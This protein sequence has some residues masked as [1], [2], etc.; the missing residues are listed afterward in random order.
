M[1]NNENK[2]V[3]LN[4]E[5]GMLEAVSGGA[6]P[7]PPAKAGFFLHQVTARDCLI[8]IANKYHIPNW[9]DIKVWNPKIPANNLIYT[10]DYLYISNKYRP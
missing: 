9:R 1:E 2:M 5:D 3:E 10:G 7:V 6:Y 4:V 8:R